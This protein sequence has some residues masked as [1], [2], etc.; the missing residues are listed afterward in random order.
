[1]TRSYTLTEELLPGRSIG[2]IV[3]ALTGR[4]SVSYR[5]SLGNIQSAIVD[6]P[7]CSCCDQPVN[8]CRCEHDRDLLEMANVSAEEIEAIQGNREHEMA[9]L[10]STRRAA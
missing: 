6:E 7:L 5:D 4:V 3:D 2:S 10:A 9:R 1:M 8:E